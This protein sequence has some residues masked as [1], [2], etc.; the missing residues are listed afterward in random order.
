[1]ETLKQKHYDP[2]ENFG[3]C[4][5]LLRASSGREPQLDP[6]TLDWT[7]GSRRLRALGSR[8]IQECAR[9]RDDRSPLIHAAFPK[10]ETGVRKAKAEISETKARWDAFAAGVARAETFRRVLGRFMAQRDLG[11]DNRV[12][13][14]ATATFEGS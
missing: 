3:H 12:H 8:R 5:R 11:V 1:M 7:S 13:P 9:R 4:T 14:R 10:N 6:T 2:R